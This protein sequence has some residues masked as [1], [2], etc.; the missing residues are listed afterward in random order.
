MTRINEKNEDKIKE[1][2]EFI[3]RFSA[4]KSKAKQA[5][6]RRKLLDKLTVEEMPAFYPQVPVYLGFQMDREPGKEILTVEEL[7]KTI[8]GVKVLDNISFRVERGDKV[9]FV[10]DNEI[11]TTTLFK[12]LMGE[13][14]PDA[15]SYNGA[16]APFSPISPRTTARTFNGCRAEPFGMAASVRS[17]RT[18][19]R[20]ICA[21]FW[22]GCSSPATMYSSLCVSSPAVRRSAACFPR[23]MMYG[24][25]V[26]VL[27]QPTN[28]LDLESI[29]AVNNGLIEFKGIIL[30]ASHDHQFVQ[31]V[32]NRI[33][34]ILPGGLADRR[35]SYDDYIESEIAA[36]QRAALMQA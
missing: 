8:D 11:A 29:T 2:Q 36:Q 5:T 35:E 4:N 9:A 23:M 24:A 31:T 28:H 14:E 1:L 13:L 10:G 27:D 7:S 33:M 16:S 17:L 25:N 34:E 18:T 19:P 3:S 32:A 26:L 15:G 20:L 6:S 12:I 21:A 22:D 30:F